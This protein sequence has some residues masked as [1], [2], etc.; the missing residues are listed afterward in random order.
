[1][2]RLPTEQAITA[3]VGAFMDMRLAREEPPEVAGDRRA[4]RGK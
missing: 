2:E 3:Q 1:M 4:G